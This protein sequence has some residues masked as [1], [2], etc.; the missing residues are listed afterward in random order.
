MTDNIPP[1][2][3][4]PAPV[5][6]ARADQVTPPVVMEPAAHSAPAEVSP[7]GADALRAS[8]DDAPVTAPKPLPPFTVPAE[9]A[10]IARQVPNAP[11]TN[12][13]TSASDD[14]PRAGIAPSASGASQRGSATIKDILAP[15]SGGKY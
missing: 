4:N 12:R 9:V 5:Q 2:E 11:L 8:G 15:A 6:P 10:G 7:M 14:N 13:A 3:I 1:A